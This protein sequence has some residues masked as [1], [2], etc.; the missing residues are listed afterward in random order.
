MQSLS[1][2]FYMPPCSG[3]NL[4]MLE[5]HVHLNAEGYVI[6]ERALWKRMDE[7]QSLEL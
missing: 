6:F 4:D 3:I 5:G 7:V 1:S 2:A